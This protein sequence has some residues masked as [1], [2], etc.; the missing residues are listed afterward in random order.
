[1]FCPNCGQELPDGSK[2]C[3]NCGSSIETTLSKVEKKANQISE[4]V[5]ATASQIA[6]SVGSGV[7]N[8]TNKASDHAKKHV[9]RFRSWLSKGDNKF[10][11]A[12]CFFLIIPILIALIAPAVTIKTIRPKQYINA[13]GIVGGVG[14]FFGHVLFGDPGTE[15]GTEIVDNPFNLNGFAS[16]VAVTLYSIVLYRNKNTV[17]HFDKN[18]LDK[19]V[20]VLHFLNL[21]FLLTVCSLFTTTSK[22]ILPFMKEPVNPAVILGIAAALSAISMK[23]IS[24][25]FWIIAVVAI[26]MNLS[27][28]NKWQG[29]SA[30]YVLSA[31]ISYVI[32]LLMLKFFNID[33]E[34]LKRDFASPIQT[35]TSDVKA[36][37][38]SGKEVVN[39]A[40]D[41]SKAAVTMSTGIPVAAIPTGNKEKKKVNNESEE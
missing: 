14:N 3:G 11:Y 30:V 36:T 35:I 21:V 13:G 25:I 7:K 26:L 41:V 34:E 38:E 12:A 27:Q 6:E 8:V 23:A 10:Y 32:Q 39:S 18:N 1:M 24:G 4:S 33:L 37:I 19:K 40:V 31:Y 17:M 28:F 20:I 16:I 9:G 15:P 5:G 29:Y 22:L 2:F